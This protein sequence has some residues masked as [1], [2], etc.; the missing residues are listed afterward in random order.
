MT[1]SSDRP[2]DLPRWLVIAAPIVVQAIVLIVAL[3]NPDAAAGMV[4][5]EQG[6]VEHL[7]VVVLLPGIALGAYGAFLAFKRKLMPQWWIPGWIMMWVLACIYF[8]G[9][10]ISWG[11]HYFGWDTP[12]S[13]TELNDQDETNL[14]NM[15]SWLDQKPRLLVELWVIIG[16]IIIPIVHRIQGAKAP[17]VKRFDYWCWPTAA[18]F[19]AACMM[20]V[21]RIAEG[22]EDAMPFITP[23]ASSE[24]REYATAFF[25][26]LYLISY[27]WR[28][29]SFAAT[30]QSA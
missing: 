9:E 21:S 15:S 19:V 2:R 28:V 5:K 12:E 6:I 4:A 8:G 26:S 20:V 30:R 1:D 13:L 7:T 29:R 16:G 18:C 25:L 24:T 14:H 23:L 3:I 27:A 10:E 17:G 22:L 11:Q